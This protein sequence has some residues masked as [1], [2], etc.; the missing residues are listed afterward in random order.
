ME[1]LTHLKHF[2]FQLMIIAKFYKKQINANKLYILTY[3]TKPQLS[4]TK[5]KNKFSIHYPNFS[6]CKS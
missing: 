5:S 4:K 1:S 2:F 3:K 6:F